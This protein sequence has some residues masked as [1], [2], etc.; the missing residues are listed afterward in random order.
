MRSK[1]PVCENQTLFI[2]SVLD[3]EANSRQRK[4]VR[5]VPLN[6]FQHSLEAAPLIGSH[7][8]PTLLGN[9]KSWHPVGTCFAGY[10]VFWHKKS[11]L[12]IPEQVVWVEVTVLF[13]P[14]ELPLGQICSFALQH[15]WVHRKI[16]EVHRKLSTLK[17]SKGFLGWHVSMKFSPVHSHPE[18]TNGNTR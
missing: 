3:W 14:R 16:W 8:R 7:C 12:A 10:H 17:S 15:P 6:S 5:L 9:L 13:S 2:V 11:G 18:L 4:Q 1:L